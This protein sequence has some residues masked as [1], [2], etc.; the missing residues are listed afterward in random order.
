MDFYV[1]LFAAIVAIPLA[2][3]CIASVVVRRR[4]RL[5]EAARQRAPTHELVTG[6]KWAVRFEG[7]ERFETGKR[8]LS[9]D[10]NCSES[11]L[12]TSLKALWVEVC[13]EDRQECRSGR[14][15]NFFEL[16]DCGIAAIIEELERRAGQSNRPSSIR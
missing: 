12:H 3:L 1:L 7:W 13:E 6:A 16:Y 9:L 8:I 10:D 5:R 2:W 11:V 15:S 4:D 14:D